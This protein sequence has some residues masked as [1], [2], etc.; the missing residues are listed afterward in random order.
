M[1]LAPILPSFNVAYYKFILNYATLL[2]EL[3]TI[4]LD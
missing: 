3:V 4:W 2:P 1:V